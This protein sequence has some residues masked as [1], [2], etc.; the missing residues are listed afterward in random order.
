MSF[1]KFLKEEK[2]IKDYVICFT[3]NQGLIPD[4]K[5]K[6]I[7]W[8]TFEK[9]YCNEETIYFEGNNQGVTLV[10]HSK[11]NMENSNIH[12]PNT[13][14]FVKENPKGLYSQFEILMKELVK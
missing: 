14:D 13:F 12:I 6:I 8:K 2:L 1:N 11:K 3:F 7:D 9:R 5:G 4:I 10:F